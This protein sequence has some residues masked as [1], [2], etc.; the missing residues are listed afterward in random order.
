[1][2][3]IIMDYLDN[4][5][6]T[7]VSLDDIEQSDILRIEI[8]VVTGDEIATITRIDGSNE[9]FDSSH[10]R[11]ANLADYYYPIYIKSKLNIISQF[12]SRK[13]SYTMEKW[14]NDF[15]EE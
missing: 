2:N 9:Q 7:G 5:I 6:D 8:D 11:I 4:K 1:M 3:L 12:N 13:N 15:V 14:S 10:S